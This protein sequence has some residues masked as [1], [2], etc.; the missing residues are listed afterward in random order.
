M[1]IERWMKV[2]KECPNC[3]KPITSNVRSIVLDSYIDKMVENLSTEMMTKRKEMIQERKGNTS[4][5]VYLTLC[6]LMYSR[7]IPSLDDFCQ[8]YYLAFQKFL[9]FH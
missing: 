4:L 6:I 5:V 2:K 1:C 3:R 8:K 9:S 7:E